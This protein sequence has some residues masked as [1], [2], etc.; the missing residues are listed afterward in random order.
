MVVV[1]RLKDDRT[2][3][4]MGDVLFLESITL[5]PILKRLEGIGHI[6]RARHPEDEQQVRVRLT[7]RGLAPH[8]EAAIIVAC[9]GEALGMSESEL[10]RSTEYLPAATGCRTTGRISIPIL[11]SDDER[12]AKRR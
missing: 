3:K 4:A 8:P 10:V 5:T 1:L 12:V 11:R 9:A 2:V 7:D 6:A